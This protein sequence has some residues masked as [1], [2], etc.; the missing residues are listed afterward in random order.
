MIA[1]MGETASGKTWL[2]ERIASELGAQLVNADSFQVYRGM[3][4][5]TAK[6]TDKRKYLLLDIRDPRETFSVGEFVELARTICDEAWQQGRSVVFVGGTGLNLRALFEEYSAL[7]SAP[8][9]KLRNELN[10]KLERNGLNSLVMELEALDPA[11][12]SRVDLANPVR[13]IRAIERARMDSSV[14]STVLPPFRKFKFAISTPQA[15]LNDRIENRVREMVQNGWTLEIERLREQGYRPQ[16]AGFR[17]IG[18]RAMW[19]V[20][21]GVSNLEQAV[22]A[23]IVETRQYAKRQRTWLRSEPNLIRLSADT[24][25]SLLGEALREIDVN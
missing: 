17:A 7:A 11:A 5:G 21:E 24:E 9:P 16:D 6:P 12:H 2:A 15:S 14:V 20:V 18:Y 8:D 10:A 1:V 19:D 13:V 22:E 4:I 3:D 23:T 25:S